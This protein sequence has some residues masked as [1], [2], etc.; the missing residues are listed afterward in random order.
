MVLAEIRGAAVDIIRGDAPGTVIGLLMDARDALPLESIAQ[1]LGLSLD[2]VVERIELLEE[3]DFCER[4]TRD[5][6]TKAIAFAAYTARNE[7]HR[8]MR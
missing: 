3:E 4:V 8:H 6:L 7:Q 5:G 2:A 1:T